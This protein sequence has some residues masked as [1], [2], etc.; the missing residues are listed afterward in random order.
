VKRNQNDLPTSLYPLALKYR[1]TISAAEG[2]ICALPT[3]GFEKTSMNSS[4]F[5]DDIDDDDEIGIT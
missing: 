1:A 4:N 3:S 5:R 2:S